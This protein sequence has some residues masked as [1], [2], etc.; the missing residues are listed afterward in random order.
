[1]NFFNFDNNTED[2][3]YDKDYSEIDNNSTIV[4]NILKNK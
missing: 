3:F 2:N 1:M 4:D